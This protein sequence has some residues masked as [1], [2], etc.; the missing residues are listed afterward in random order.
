MST[1]QRVHEI[2]PISPAATIGVIPP[3]RRIVEE[4][5]FTEF[6]ASMTARE[7]GAPGGTPP[8]SRA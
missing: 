8:S 6:S 3:V 7:S 5:R 4:R 1:N 2:V